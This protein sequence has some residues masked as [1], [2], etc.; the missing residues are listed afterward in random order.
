MKNYLT[1]ASMI[2]NEEHYVQEWLTFHY[3][4]GFEQFVIVLHKC[5]DKTEERI[6][7]LPFADKIHVHKVVGD[8]QHAQMSAFVWM[9]EQ[10]GNNTEWMMFC[11]SDEYSFGTNT[12]DFREVLAKY[13]DFGGLFLNWLEYGHSNLIH[14][15]DNLCI[16]A[17]TKRA[18]ADSWWHASGKS[19]IKPKE[20]LRP[21]AP[22]S[23][24][25]PLGYSFLSPHL[26][27]TDKPT[28][29]TD[30]TPVS[31]RHWWVSEHTCHE[32][33]RCNHY[34]YRSQEDWLTKCRRGNTCD[35]RKDDINEVGYAIDEWQNG[36][37]WSIDDPAAVR[38]AE[39]IKAVLLR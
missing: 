38:F 26:F 20:L 37:D 19:I 16:E 4:Q 34:R 5:E 28:V 30:F 23:A 10:Y 24:T 39:R 25:D 15:P 18:A 14:R 13:D 8:T 2:R 22:A 21:Y 35:A 17:F 27:K 33:A 32:V 36:G 29:H 7:A 1:L 11:D 6:K 31:Y 9:A 3:V 12:D